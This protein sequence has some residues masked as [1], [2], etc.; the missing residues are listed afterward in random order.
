MCVQLDIL[1]NF[2]IAAQ[3]HVSLI[4]VVFAGFVN[5]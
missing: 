2:F 4:C 3:I 1:G 5:V